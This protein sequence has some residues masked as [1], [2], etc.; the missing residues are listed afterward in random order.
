MKRILILLWTLFVLGVVSVVL[1]FILIAKGVIGY[2]PPIEELQNPIDKYASQVISEDNVVLGTYARV[3]NN[4]VYATYDQ[5]SPY[6]VQ[7]LIATEDKRFTRHSGVDLKGIFR[8]FFKSILLGQRSSGGG[9]TI[10]QQLA[11]QLYSPNA[12]NIWERI[13]Q[14]P[15]EWVI[16]VKLER[17]YTKE[18]IITL[19]LNQFDFLY[20]AVGVESAAQTYFNKK[21]SS[22]KAEE[23]ALLVGMA[24]NPSLYNPKRFPERAKDRRDVVL[25]LMAQEGYITT[26]E[27]DSL[28]KLPVTLKFNVK[29]H[30]DGLAPYFREYLRKVLMAKEPNEKD[31]RGW[32]KE[33]YERDLYEWNNNPLY[34]WCHK[35]KKNDGTPYDIYTDGLKIYTPINSKMQQHAEDAMME[36]LGIYLQKAFNKEK[37]GRKN[38]PFSSSISTEERHTIIERA[39]KQSDRYRAMKKNGAKESEIA[40]SFDTPV[41]MSIFA[42]SKEGKAVLRDTVMT[43]RDSILYLKSFLRSGFMAMDAV[44]GDV[45]AYVGGIDFRTFKYDMVSQGRRQVG[46]VMKPYLYAMAM[47]EGFTPCDEML[48]E[49]P[50]IMTEAGTVWTPKNAGTSRV[51]ESVTIQW[52]LQN[53][54][55]WVTAWLMSQMSPYAFVDLLQS[56]GITGKIDPVMSVCLGTHEISVKEM[57]SGFSTFATS[58]V[59]SEPLFVTRIEDQY[60]NV[61][62]EFMSKHTDVLPAKASYKT[63]YMLRSV[64]DGGTGSRMRFRYGVKAEMG[65]KTGTSQN[66]SDGWFMCF[67]PRISTGCWV[68]GEDRSIHFDGL[69]MGQGAN[70]ALPIV[71]NFFK[72]IYGDPAL[73]KRAEDLGISPALQFDLPEEYDHPCDTL[74]SGSYVEELK[75]PGIDDLF[76]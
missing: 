49:Q 29:S 41:E 32:Q 8:A 69:Q 2:M 28:K 67:T 33:D 23:A 61:L 26:Q 15:I 14:K 10:T 73:Q 18:E 50:Y 39:I 38:A 75:Q 60:G 19:Y 11:K 59:R 30:V 9:S 4:R 40:K 12:D 74:K 3:N 27:S 54:S 53:S 36:H 34:G 76:E 48:H 24:K 70:T 45:R 43:P 16:A 22:L 52:G 13:I 1:V 57:V 71:A 63:L 20:Q 7:A 47:N 5:L 6:I 44:T 31:Y 65:G 17:F 55:N 37:R 25:N 35:N 51:G 58:G 72:K 56:F 46:S 66:Q 21:A 64:M 42:Y 68:G 62:A